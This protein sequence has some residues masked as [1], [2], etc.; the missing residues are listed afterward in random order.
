MKKAWNIISNSVVSVI[1]VLAISMMIFTIFSVS[2]IDRNDRSIFGYRLLIVLSDSMSATDFG[3]GDLIFVKETDPQTLKAGDIIAF[4]SQ[5][6]ENYG[7]TVAHK[8]RRAATDAEGNPGFI[9]YGTTTDVDD[10][11]VVTWP[12]ILGQYQMRLPKVGTF[13]AFLKTVPGYL[14]LILLPF[15]LLIIFQG[16]HCVGLFREYRKEEM[17]EIQ[18]E[19]KKLLEEREATRHMMEELNALKQQKDDRMDGI[20]SNGMSERKVDIFQEAYERGEWVESEENMQD[21]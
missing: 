14:L 12:Y 6:S 15:L 16:V 20:G 10:S 18:A 8:I 19:R 1:A 3:A 21:T 17:A 11:G 9:T 2:T 13:F 4:T 7:Q 5:N